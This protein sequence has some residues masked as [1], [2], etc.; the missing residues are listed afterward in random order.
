MEKPPRPRRENIITGRMLWRAWGVLGVTSAVLSSGGF[1]WYLT[2]H[3]WS[4]GD[5]VGAGSPLHETYLTATTMLF[6][7]IVACQ[8]GTAMA[9][10]TDHVSLLRVGILSNRL[11]LWGIAFELVFTALVDL[12]AGT[13]GLARHPPARMAGAAGAGAV[14]GRGVAGRRGGQAVGRHRSSAV[15]V[16]G[17]GPGRARVG[18]R[19]ALRGPRPHGAVRARKRVRPR[20]V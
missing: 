18:V 13:A 6:A 10:R 5:D 19:H 12:R 8:I 3:G 11:L 20:K 17:V 15:H 4:P 7:G 14:P 2:A 1:L 9:A 16:T